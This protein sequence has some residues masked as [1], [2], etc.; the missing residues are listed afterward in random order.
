[1]DA[2]G[3]LLERY[4]P[5]VLHV[6]RRILP[7][8]HEAEDAFQATFLLLV[9]KAHTIRKRDA[10]AAWLHGSAR[11]L[12]VKLRRQARKRSENERKA[13]VPVTQEPG[14]ETA[15]RELHQVLE[16]ELAL[17]PHKYRAPLVLCYLEGKKH[18]EAARELGLPLGTLHSYVTRAREAL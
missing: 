16:E 3:V 17:L 2:F 5:M 4:G 10:L 7:D 6:C 18:E 12:A 8:P 13:A 1:E 11:R 9:Q 15:W 14:F